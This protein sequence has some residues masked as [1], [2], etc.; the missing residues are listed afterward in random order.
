VGDA[1]QLT[2]AL[3]TRLI[4]SETGLERLRAALGQVYYFT[5]PRV[6]L[7]QT[8]TDAKSSDVVAFA[9]SQMT[10]S[11]DMALGIQYTPNL[12]RS[13]KFTA[14]AHYSPVPGSVLNAAYRYARG[15]VDSTDPATSGIK[16]VDLSTQW[17]ITR[18]ISALA[19]WNWSTQDRKLLEGS[20]ASSTMRAAGSFARWRTGSSRPRSSIRPHSSSSWSSRACRASA[21][22][23]SR[24]CGRISPD[25]A[26]RTRFPNDT[27]RTFPPSAR[28][29]C[30]RRRRRGRPGRARPP[31]PR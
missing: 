4:E 3:A 6:T 30:L 9:S 29:A 27:D 20:R 18:T 16:Q 25:T 7:G 10:R 22:I 28:R 11:V 19:R 21:S 31:P 13:Q 12:S 14:E 1:N 2:V 23:R 8:A 24:R 5:P 26:G 15:S 17:P